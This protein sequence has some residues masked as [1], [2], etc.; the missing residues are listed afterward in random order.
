VCVGRVQPELGACVEDSLAGAPL[1]APCDPDAEVSECAGICVEV[2]GAAFCSR[3]CVLGDAA[4]CN[5]TSAPDASSGLCRSTEEVI[6]SVGDVGFCSLL[7]DCDTDC[8]HA[9]L[10]CVAFGSAVAW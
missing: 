8:G 5:G 10:L 2:D 9:D 1:G 7:C 3:R 4:D 6:G